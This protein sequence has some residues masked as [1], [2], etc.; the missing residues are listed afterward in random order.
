MMITEEAST[1]GGKLAEKL[2]QKEL[3]ILALQNAMSQLKATNDG[4]AGK[5]EDQSPGTQE[6]YLIREKL[7]LLDE[8]LRAKQDQHL[9]SL[10]AREHLDQTAT[11]GRRVDYFDK[12]YAHIKAQAARIAELEGEAARLTRERDQADHQRG[13]AAQLATNHFT[14]LEQAL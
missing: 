4:L 10:F 1:Q 8:E 2:K 7:R 6:L 5:R 13:Q 14:E 9:I 12:T 3:Y 11:L